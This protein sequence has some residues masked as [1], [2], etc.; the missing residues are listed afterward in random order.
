MMSLDMIHSESRKAARRASEDGVLPYIVE[1]EDL[2]AFK[3]GGTFPF[4]FT[5]T[6]R[7]KGWKLVKRYFVDSSGWGKAGEPALTREQFLAVLEPGYGYAIL[8]A[9]QFQVYVGKFEQV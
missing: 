6:K 1:R 3:R 9:G 4:P 7:W 5:G 2:V 8:E